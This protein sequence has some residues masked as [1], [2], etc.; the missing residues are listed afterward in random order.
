[1]RVG[2]RYGRI[3]RKGRLS[4]ATLTSAPANAAANT[5]LTS[6]D[7][8]DSAKFMLRSGKEAHAKHK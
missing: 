1:M 4:P 7:S 8:A 3:Y 6:G 2:N 5:P